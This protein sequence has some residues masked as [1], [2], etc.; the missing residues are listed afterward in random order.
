MQQQMAEDDGKM[1]WVDNAEVPEW[2]FDKITDETSF[3]LDSDGHLVICFNEGDVAPMYMG[4]VQFVIPDEVV[5]VSESNG[6]RFRCRRM[7]D[8]EA[9]KSGAQNYFYGFNRGSRD[10]GI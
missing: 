5:A 2:N 7:R 4:C 6:S 8:N 9:C 10:C 3:Y 1:Y